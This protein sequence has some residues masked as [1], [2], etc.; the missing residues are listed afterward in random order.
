MH[1]N[2]CWSFKRSFHIVQSKNLPFFI[3][4]PL[5]HALQHEASVLKELDAMPPD[6]FR[7]ELRDSLTAFY[8]NNFKKS[9][10]EGRPAAKPLSRKIVTKT[11]SV[12]DPLVVPCS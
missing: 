11:A 5:V 8:E 9:G 6:E 12:P 10:A 3:K 1:C 2:N 7:T 4:T